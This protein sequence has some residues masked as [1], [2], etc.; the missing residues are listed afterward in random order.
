MVGM[1]GWNDWVLKFWRWRNLVLRV[2]CGKIKLIFNFYGF[3]LII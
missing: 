2:G 3:V 1:A